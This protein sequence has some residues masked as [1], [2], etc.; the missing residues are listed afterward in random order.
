MKKFKDDFLLSVI[1]P[2]YKQEKTIKKDLLR[3]KKALD[4]A[5]WNYEMVIVIDG[6]VDKS[7]QKAKETASSRLKVF[8]YKENQGKGHA[9]RFG[10]QKA[11]GDYIAFIDA[12]ME[13]DPL[14]LSMLLQHLVWY[15]ADIIV[16]SKRHPV[17]H[18]DYP[19]QRKILSWG[20]F[21]IVRIL[22]GL[23]ITDTQ[24][25]IKVFKKEVLED[26]L[27]VLLVK[28]YAFDIEMLAVA[29]AF[30]YQRIFDAPIK[31]DHRLGNITSA[32][33]LRTIFLMLQDTMAIFYRLKIL[34][35]YDK[36]RCS[37]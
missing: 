28:K 27:P 22:F 31:L 30:G 11:R 3:I 20:Y 34:R 21:T 29:Y 16:G 14:G 7:Y 2:V 15:D 18:V 8:A 12:G 36:K 37:K 13:I 32:A 35:Y 25:G 1:I 10:M 9:I 6:K 33:T 26:I 4:E 17:S 23:K 5:G 24:A 19:L